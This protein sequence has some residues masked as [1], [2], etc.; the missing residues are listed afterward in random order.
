MV[1]CLRHLRERSPFFT[2]AKKRKKITECRDTAPL[3]FAL[4]WSE[5]CKP[6]FEL[7][8]CLNAEKALNR[9][10]K[11]FF[12]LFP[13]FCSTM[14]RVVAWAQVEFLSLSNLRRC[15]LFDWLLLL[16]SKFT[17]LGDCIMGDGF[18]AFK[19]WFSEMAFCIKAKSRALN[20]ALKCCK[21][22]KIEL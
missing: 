10:L 18:L 12:E 19:V 7:Y 17:F 9:A 16:L 20:R 1:W 21:S 11:C 15:L 6:C 22:L 14:F 4:K 13:D 8:R 2:H 5:S 3:K